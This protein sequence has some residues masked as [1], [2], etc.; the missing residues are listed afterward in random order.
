MIV[1]LTPNMIIIIDNRGN[2]V[3][4]YKPSG[5]IAR[6]EYEQIIFSGIE[7][8][9]IPLAQIHNKKIQ[10]LP[11]QKEN[12]LYIVDPLVAYHL[13]GQRDD[14]LFVQDDNSHT[15]QTDRFLIP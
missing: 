11:P 4:S 8:E 15:I 6:L 3:H 10:G 5:I 2:P 12:V 9:N 1:N 7:A 13:K 14:L